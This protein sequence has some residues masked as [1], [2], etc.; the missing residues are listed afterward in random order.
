M[1][2]HTGTLFIETPRLT[3]RRFTYDDIPDMLMNWI[4]NIKVQREYGEPTYDSPDEVRE[5]LNKWIGRYGD[6]DFYRW[7]IVLKERDENIGQIAFCRVYSELETAEIEYCIG[8]DFWGRGYASEALNA[9]IDFSFRGPKFNKLE[10]FHRAAN[11]RSGRVLQKTVMKQVDTV[12]RFEMTGSKPEGD[13]C[14]AIEREAY[15]S[16]EQELKR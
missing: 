1:L 16:M 10:A 6:D 3:L 8:E 5:L 13:V 2:K 7:A 15:L 4:A 11:P 9:V 14:Y 12:R